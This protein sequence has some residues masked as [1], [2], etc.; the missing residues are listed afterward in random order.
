MIVQDT[1]DASSSIAMMTLTTGPA[2]RISESTECGSF[3][4]KSAPSELLHERLRQRPGL[5]GVRRD[6]GRADR[7]ADQELAGRRPAA[8]FLREGDRRAAERLEPRRHRELVVER[9]SPMV[10]DVRFD[11]DELEPFVPPEPRLDR[12]ITRLNSSH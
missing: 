1:S 11:H 9:R 6:A 4:F 2:A 7:R 3:R 10:T 5:Q 8:D 12:K